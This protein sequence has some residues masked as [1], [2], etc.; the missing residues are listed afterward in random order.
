[1]EEC[2]TFLLLGRALFI[3]RVE[4]SSVLFFS[5]RLSLPSP[6]GQSAL[7]P[8]SLLKKDSGADAAD[9][10][11]DSIDFPQSGNPCGFWSFG[12]LLVQERAGIASKMGLLLFQFS[13]TP[14]LFPFGY[15][16]AFFPPIIPGSILSSD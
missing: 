1:M 12:L 5:S 4:D 14:P 15:R 6:A 8:F 2:P 10:S 9:L 7:P 11:S 16:L 3:P 13:P